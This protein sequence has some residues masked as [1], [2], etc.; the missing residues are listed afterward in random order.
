MIKSIGQNL[1]KILKNPGL[2]SAHTLHA[3]H[4]RNYRYR[5]TPLLMAGRPHMYSWYGF[6]LN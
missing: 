1:I 5:S 2:T 4:S 6:A 3:K